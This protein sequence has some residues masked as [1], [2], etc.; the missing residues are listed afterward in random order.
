QIAV[1]VLGFAEHR[2]H[3]GRERRDGLDGR[4]RSFLRALFLSCLSRLSCP[5][6]QFRSNDRTDSGRERRLVKARRAVHAV[7]IEQRER[8]IAERRRAIDERFGKRRALEKA[9]GGGGVEFDVM[10]RH[11]RPSWS[12]NDGID[13][14]PLG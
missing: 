4:D 1:A 10:R 7:A 3:K 2:K 13:E 9:E 8:G 5:N 14:P 6:R 12:I 11:D